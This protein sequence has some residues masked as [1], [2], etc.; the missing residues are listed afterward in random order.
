M[1]KWK[2]FHDTV[3]VC[4]WITFPSQPVYWTDLLILDA[5]SVFLYC[6]YSCC[7]VYL[8]ECLCLYWMGRGW[9][10][11]CSTDICLPTARPPHPDPVITTE[12]TQHTNILCGLFHHGVMVDRHRRGS[13]LANESGWWKVVTDGGPCR[14]QGP[15]Q[16]L[17]LGTGYT[18]RQNREEVYV[19]V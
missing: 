6:C 8:S 9:V 13:T 18:F 10:L 17:P 5:D 11:S 1:K 12:T 7:A 14:A 16:I 2:G 3:H 19:C 4:M 15:R